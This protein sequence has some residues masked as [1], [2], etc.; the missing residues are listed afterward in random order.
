MIEPN[1]ILFM[2]VLICWM[3]IEAL[4][5]II[6]GAGKIKKDTHYDDGN[7]VIGIVLLIILIIVLIQ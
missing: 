7:I 2:N 5:H 6:V 1:Y 3:L 4:A